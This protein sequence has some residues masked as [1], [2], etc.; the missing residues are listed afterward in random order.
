MTASILDGRALA[1]KVRAQVAEVVGSDYDGQTPVRHLLEIVTEDL[2]PGQVA[3]ISIAPSQAAGYAD[4]RLQC[5]QD[6]F[7]HRPGGDHVCGRVR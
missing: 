7:F 6:H 4:S 1:T 2:A 3:G 5:G